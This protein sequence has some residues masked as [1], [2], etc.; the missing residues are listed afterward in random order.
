LQIKK[1][2]QLVYSFVAS[3]LSSQNVDVRFISCGA[4]KKD[5]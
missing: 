1:N 5:T 4:R 2:R 3:K